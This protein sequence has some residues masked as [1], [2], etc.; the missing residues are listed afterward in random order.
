MSF[1]VVDRRQIA[2][3]RW[4]N[5]TNAYDGFRATLGERTSDWQFDFFAVQ[6]IE[7]RMR[8]FDH[9]DD[10]RWL[11]GMTGASRRWSNV[12][13]L[14]PYYFILD[15]DRVSRDLPDREIHTLGFHLFGPIGDTGFDWDI[16]TMFQCGRDGHRNHR[17]FAQFAELGYT[18]NHAWKPRVSYAAVYASG[19]RFP[20]DDVSERWD[21]LFNSGHSYT[22]SDYFILQNVIMSRL[23][24]EFAPIKNVRVEG[25]Y[26][27]YWLASPRDAW[28]P[29]TRIDPEG[30]SGDFVGQDL[31]ARVRIQLDPRVEL[32][33]G[34]SHFFPG[35]FVRNTG[36][37]PDSDFFY[38]S[39]TFQLFE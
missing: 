4:R 21:R 34:Y 37:S 29:T 11:Y 9:G 28:I 17:A 24:L 19:D 38:V 20:N 8:Q 10:E 15:D 26:G 25:A 6:P 32:E 2:R 30:R 18:F 7:L 33:L 12:I 39:T 5:T 13:T 3:P 23:R 27:A 22:I 35:P 16:D 14:E 31:E 1:D 36:P